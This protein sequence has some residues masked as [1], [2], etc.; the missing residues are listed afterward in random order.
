MSEV[1]AM[2]EFVPMHRQRNLR[3]VQ[4][5]KNH[6]NLRLIGWFQN[7]YKE[8]CEKQNDIRNKKIAA[9]KNAAYEHYLDYYLTNTKGTL[10]IHEALYKSKITICTFAEHMAEMIVM[11]RVKEGKLEECYQKLQKHLQENKRLVKR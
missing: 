9:L 6:T 3:V 5:R 10:D 1:I 7:A 4:K 8:F 11:E 2:R